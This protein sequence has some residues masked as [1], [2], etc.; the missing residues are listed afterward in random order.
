MSVRRWLALGITF[1]GIVVLAS[2]QFGFGQPEPKDPEKKKDGEKKDGPFGKKDGGF[3]KGPGGFG[4]GSGGFGGR[5]GASMGQI[6]PVFMQD[7]LKLNDDQKKQ[8]ETLQKDLDAK[9][10]KILTEDQRKQYKEM[11][12]RGPGG[13]GRPGGFGPPGEG[14]G[15]DGPP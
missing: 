12:E 4:K 9:L 1:L 6:M 15:P 14:K 13:F 11:R 3:G 8:V 5:F 2:P 7:M 10:D